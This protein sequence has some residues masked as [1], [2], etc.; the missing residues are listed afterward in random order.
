[1]GD[2]RIE[3]VEGDIVPEVLAPDSVGRSAHGDSAQP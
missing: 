1:M 2:S 3:N